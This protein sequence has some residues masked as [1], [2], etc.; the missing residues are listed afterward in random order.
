MNS[1][2]VNFEIKAK[3]ATWADSGDD[4]VEIKLANYSNT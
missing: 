1:Q 4:N 3:A 2:F